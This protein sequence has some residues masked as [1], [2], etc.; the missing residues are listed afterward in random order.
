MNVNVYIITDRCGSE[1]P[2]CGR[3]IYKPIGSGFLLRACMLRIEVAFRVVP[4]ER[5]RFLILE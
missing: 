2:A 4:C 1:L 5:M 3:S